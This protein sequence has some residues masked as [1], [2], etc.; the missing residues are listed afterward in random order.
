MSKHFSKKV[1]VLVFSKDRALQLDATLRSFYLHCLDATKL[2]QVTVLY[3]TSGARHAC[4]YRE[5]QNEYPDVNFLAEKNFRRDV[6]ET[7]YL[8]SC[9]YTLY[10]FVS[11]VNSFGFRPGTRAD[12]FIHLFFDPLRF[13]LNKRLFYI[14]PGE[15]PAILFLVDDNLFVRNFS[16]GDC[17]SMLY[18]IPDA[19]GFSLRLGRNIDYNY[20]ADQPQPLPCFT[21]ESPD[22]LSFRWTDASGD[23]GYPLEVSSSIYLLT[24]L[25]PFLLAISFGTPNNLET[26]LSMR[27]NFFRHSHPKLLCFEHSVTFCNPINLVQTEYN[28]RAGRYNSPDELSERFARGE[29][30]DVTAY[31]GF[32]PR[33]CHQEVELYLKYS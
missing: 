3:K 8:P 10:R 17:L 2:A 12:K 15:S 29:R 18:R 20:M 11:F 1:L 26:A 7:L 24:F 23:F 13:L 16:L 33:S 14:P 27:A 31:N 25:F 28:N 4:Q 21:L 22:V 6:L 30:I 32:S 5:L 9:S 19:L